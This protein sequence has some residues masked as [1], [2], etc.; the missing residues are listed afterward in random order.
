M[1]DFFCKPMRGCNFTYV[2]GARMPI[3][4]TARQQL[5]QQECQQKLLEL[6]RRTLLAAQPALV[7]KPLH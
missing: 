1:D 5:G 3:W 4:P 6:T 2:N 7:N